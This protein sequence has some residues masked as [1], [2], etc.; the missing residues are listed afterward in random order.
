[1]SDYKEP[2]PGNVIWADRISK[3]LPYNHCG[4][5]EGGGYVIH[6]AAPDPVSAKRVTILPRTIA[7]ISR[8]GARPGSIAPFR[9]TT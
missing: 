7:T 1:M 4:I 6:F 5:Y 2:K 3:G 8:L 9:W